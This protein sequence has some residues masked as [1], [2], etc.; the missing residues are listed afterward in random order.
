MELDDNTPGIAPSTCLISKDEE[1]Q[2]RED[3]WPAIANFHPG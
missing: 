3:A 1:K 2:N